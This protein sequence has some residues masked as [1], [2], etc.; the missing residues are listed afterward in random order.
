MMKDVEKKEIEIVITPSNARERIVKP[1]E[2]EMVNGASRPS[3][4]IEAL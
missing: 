2:T 3:T 1:N 4:I